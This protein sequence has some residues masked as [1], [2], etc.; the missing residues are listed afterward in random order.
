[1][2]QRRSSGHPWL[3]LYECMNDFLWTGMRIFDDRSKMLQSRFQASFRCISPRPCFALPEPVILP[4][5]VKKGQIDGFYRQYK[6][7]ITVFGNYTVVFRHH[8][9]IHSSRTPDRRLKW[10]RMG[11]SQGAPALPSEDGIPV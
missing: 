3:H 11:V 10:L 1:M 2:N 9:V 5:P 4:Q 7:K 6:D 8:T